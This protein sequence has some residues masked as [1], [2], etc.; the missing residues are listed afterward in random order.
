MRI[1]KR[2]YSRGVFITWLIILVVNFGDLFA[3]ELPKSVPYCVTKS[4]DTLVFMMPIIKPLNGTNGIE[5]ETRLIT[6]PN[7]QAFYDSLKVRAYKKRLT[8]L[9]HKLLISSSASK[10]VPLKFDRADYFEQYECKV[11]GSVKFEQLDVFGPTFANPNAKATNAITKFANDIHTRT[12]KR[13]IRKNLLFKPGDPLIPFL[14]QESE[15]ILRSYE[16]IKDARFLITPRPN[17]PNLVDITI[18]TKDAFSYGLS[19]KVR[20]GIDGNYRIYNRNMFGRGHEFSTELVIRNDSTPKFGHETSYVVRNIA[21]RFI[22][23][24]LALYDSYEYRTYGLSLEREFISPKTKY[25]GGIAFFDIDKS[26]RIWLD[27]PVISTSPLKFN[28]TELWYGRKFFLTKSKNPSAPGLVASARVEHRHFFEQ[29]QNG[30]EREYFSHSVMYLGGLALTKWSHRQNNLIYGFG[31]T[32]D[33]PEGY[34]LELVG[35]YDN[36]EFL[37][38][39]YSHISF[40]KGKLLTERRSYLY[41][42]LSLGGFFNRRH[43]EQGFFD[44]EAN[45][46][47][48]MLFFGKYKARQFLNLNYTVGIRR[49]DPEGLTLNEEKGIR[50]FKSKE[51]RGTQRISL[52]SESVFFHNK[53]FYGFK[54][55]SYFFADVALIGPA[56]KFLRNQK[57]YCGVGPG[58]RIRNESLVFKTIQ[59]RLEYYPIKPADMSSFGIT[60]KGTLKSKFKNFAGRKPMPMQFR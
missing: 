56:N 49:F 27:D 42:S 58:I 50:G 28:Y 37:E 17:Q 13:F 1:A 16:F 36:N 30:E 8:K 46:F 33:I 15:R 3:K 38:R 51:A 35:G 40:A 55:A 20:N 2:K 53:D 41:T 54:M 14:M 52:S 57:V 34:R 32:E 11:I 48:R 19:L 7:T 21:G 4:G 12:K 9:M 23:L 47:S 18:Y 24:T 29:P 22:D 59:I 31:S 26:Y 6:V 60:I 44:L 10:A 45:Y 39:F 5:S 25:A 43:F